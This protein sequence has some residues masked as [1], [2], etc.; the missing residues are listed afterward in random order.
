MRPRSTAG[1]VTW[2]RAPSA[3]TSTPSGTDVAGTP[4]SKNEEF[5]AG[6]VPSAIT[7]RSQSL[8]RVKLIPSTPTA[9]DGVPG[10]GEVAMV[11]EG[12]TYGTVHATSANDT[13]PVRP[14]APATGRIVPDSSITTTSSAMPGALA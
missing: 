10:T 11:P 8:P 3:V 4:S 13:I 7:V 2:I 1:S 14:T 12:P 9:F 6:T 5:P